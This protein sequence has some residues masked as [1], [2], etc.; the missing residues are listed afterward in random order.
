MSSCLL[1][2]FE[3]LLS[4]L[5]SLFSSF[6]S[7]VGAPVDWLSRDVERVNAAS[8]SSSKTMQR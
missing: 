1:F 6:F 5:L 3:L 2:P 7:A 8:K 4:L